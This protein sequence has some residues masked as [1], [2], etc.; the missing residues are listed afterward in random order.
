MKKF[1]CLLLA[2]IFVLSLTTFANAE[3]VKIEADWAKYLGKA[4]V[5]KTV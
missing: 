4:E 5:T 1:V 3:E 2:M